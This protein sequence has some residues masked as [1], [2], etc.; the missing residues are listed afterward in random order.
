MPNTIKF[1]EFINGNPVKIKIKP[2]QQLRYYKVTQHDEGFNSVNYT[3]I[4]EDNELICTIY[5][6]GKDCDGPL[7]TLNVFTCD[8]ENVTSGNKDEEFDDVIYPKWEYKHS[9]QRDYYAEAMGY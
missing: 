7:S 3:W 5:T 8:I 1:W 9:S 6:Y 2:N 4:L